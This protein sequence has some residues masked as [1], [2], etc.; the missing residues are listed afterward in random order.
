ML[1]PSTKKLIDRISE[2]TAQR[3][4]D[5]ATGESPDTLVYDTDGYR[6]ILDGDPASVVLCDAL[7]QELERVDPAELLA[8]QQSDGSG[9]DSLVADMRKDAMR[10][11][12]GTETAIAALLDGLDRQEE[13][14][15]TDP[16]T[17]AHQPETGVSLEPDTMEDAANELD[18]PDIDA[19]GTDTADIGATPSGHP[20][21]HHMS[22][23]TAEHVDLP[24]PSET[25][26]VT[27]E[28]PLPDVGK[29]V[30]DLANQ[31]NETESEA[32]PAIGADAGPV[33]TDL[34]VFDA[35]ASE[36]DPAPAPTE[37]TPKLPP[38]TAAVLFGSGF[39][40]AIEPGPAPNNV[41]SDDSG[42]SEP[43][44]AS[45]VASPSVPP[46]LE[47][48]EP[49]AEPYA[50]PS[51]VAAYTDE[52]SEAEPSE[53]TAEQSPPR[54]D[55][56]SFGFGSSPLGAAI[57]DKTS[58]SSPSDTPAPVPTPD[59]MPEPSLE[60]MPPTPIE[61]EVSENDL[62]NASAEDEPDTENKAPQNKR[63]NP[64]I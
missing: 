15:T 9:Y 22:E 39:A 34:S 61:S 64:W 37:E 26:E 60:D 21:D 7:G 47:P 58:E 35:P 43:D 50:E 42:Q 54:P 48:V 4:I 19:L 31:V 55:I 24:E 1:H 20:V 29:A 45:E 30:A 12:L 53:P 63:F 51:E 18:R 38:Q 16:S 62:S 44:H 49:I 25:P 59:A 36:P 46:T 11:A 28:E 52:V 56:S 8:T 5:W 10:I 27:I 14:E 33:P 6:V 3:K 57:S 40:D 23:Q 32:E 2:M 17:S 13:S 41:I